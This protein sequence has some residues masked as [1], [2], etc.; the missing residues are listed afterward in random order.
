MLSGFL[1]PRRRF[2][3]PVLLAVVVRCEA[4]AMDAALGEM[5]CIDTRPSAGAPPL[6]ASGLAA[7][8]LVGAGDWPAVLRAVDD[9]K[10]DVK[11]VTGIAPE[12]LREA[13]TVVA[14]RPGARCSRGGNLPSV[15]SVQRPAP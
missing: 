15:A 8:L 9:L 3:A 13:E 4:T 5:P 2:Y 11:P 10:A 12:V 6:A 14:G 1:S 7:P